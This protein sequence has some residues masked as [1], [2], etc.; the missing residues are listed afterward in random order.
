MVR[1][2]KQPGIRRFSFRFQ[3]ESVPQKGSCTGE[4]EGR[5]IHF[6][7]SIHL[8]CELITM[9]KYC[10]YNT[11]AQAQE[12]SRGNKLLLYPLVGI[13]EQHL[14]EHLKGILENMV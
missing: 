12:N 8:I 4:G 7:Y 10:F 9:S 13:S 5:S 14:G 3:P 1:Q 6:F 11:N 2:R